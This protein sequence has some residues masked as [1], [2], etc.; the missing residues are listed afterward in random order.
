MYYLM[1]DVSQTLCDAIAS[2]DIAGYFDDK[3]FI[4]LI[5]CFLDPDLMLECKETPNPLK[6][7]Q[8]L[9][10]VDGRFQKLCRPGEESD[11]LYQL[12][13]PDHNAKLGMCNRVIFMK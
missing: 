7:E 1:Q 11:P 6:E 13:V 5:Q 4:R 3:G 12:F 9:E 2:D 8:V 10:L